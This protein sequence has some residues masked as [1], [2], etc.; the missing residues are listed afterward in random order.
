MIL[1]SEVSAK[2]VLLR[3]Y[4][5]RFDS[6]WEMSLGDIIFKEVVGYKS[7]ASLEGNFSIDISWGFCLCF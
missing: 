2:K 3:Q 7:A 1:L 4:F 5:S 6:L